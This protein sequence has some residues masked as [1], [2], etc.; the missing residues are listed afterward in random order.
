MVVFSV[1][2]M[3]KDTG[4]LLESGVVRVIETRVPHLSNRAIFVYPSAGPDTYQNVGKQI[5]YIRV[6]GELRE[7]GLVVPMGDISASLIEVAYFPKNDNPEL[8]NIREVMK[9]RWLLVFQKNLWSPEGVYVSH[10]LEAKGLS[11]ALDV[12]QLE[13]AIRDGK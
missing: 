10:D 3:V 12:S 8:A 4:I 2:F 13:L 7:S 1:F 6:D 5:R 9:A 11:E